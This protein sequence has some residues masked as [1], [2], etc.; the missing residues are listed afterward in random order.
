MTVL[1]FGNLADSAA[2]VEKED[3]FARHGIERIF[4]LRAGR[5]LN[6]WSIP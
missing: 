6:P 2:V 4:Y 1:F 3:F 5:D